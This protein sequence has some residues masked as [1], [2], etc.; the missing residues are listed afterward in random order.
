MFDG[1]SIWQLL[2]VLAIAIVIFGT[3]RLANVGSDVGKAIKSFKKAMNEDDGAPAAQQ[4]AQFTA[5]D[6]QPK[7]KAEAEADPKH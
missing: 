7:A 2:I 3:K 4:D 5:A 6:P 1:I